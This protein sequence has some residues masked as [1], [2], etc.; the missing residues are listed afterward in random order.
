MPIGCSLVAMGVLD[1]K[2]VV[3]TGAGRGLGRAFAVHAA[4]SGA[5]VVV[6]DVD[7]A[8]EVAE[9]INTEGG[10]ARSSAHSVADPNDAEALIAQAWPSSAR[11]TAWS[12]TRACGTR[13]CRG[14]KTRSGS[15]R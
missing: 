7:G 2:A 1:G 11:S 15:A 10:T 12:T 8:A 3:V 9:A 4:R 5:S 6:N 14:K 13:R